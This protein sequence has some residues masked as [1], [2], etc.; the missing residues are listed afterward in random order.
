MT[1]QEKAIKSNVFQVD[2]SIV[3]IF[4]QLLSRI[5]RQFYKILNKYTQSILEYSNSIV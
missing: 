1:T 4:W 2:L 5:T 3:M